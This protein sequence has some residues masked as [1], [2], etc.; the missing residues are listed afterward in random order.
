MGGPRF[1]GTVHLMPLPGSVR[2]GSAGGLRA[3]I[4]R[5]RRDAAGYATGGASG[6]MVENFGDVP[7]VRD[8]VGAPTVA[9]M[10]LAV[11]AV[12]E[13]SGLPVGVNVLRNDVLSA[14]AI[15]A[16]TG[17]G[18]GR[19]KV[20]VGAAGTDQGVIGG[21]AGGVEWVMRTLGAA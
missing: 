2:G 15:A 19:A 13:E 12:R 20:Y 4:E 11:A 1:V 16:M 7:F 21:R 9:A 3:V 10:T 5:A 17:G 18:F 14:V 8:R 6:L